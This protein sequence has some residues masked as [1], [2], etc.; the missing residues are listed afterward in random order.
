MRLRRTL[1][2]AGA[3]PAD[4]VES[5]V[6]LKDVSYLAAMNHP[7]REFF[8]HPTGRFPAR[9]TIGTPLVVDD[10]LVEIMLTAVVG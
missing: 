4:V 5:T 8:F 10:G 3:S 2:A 7:Y 6:F 1:E 9:T